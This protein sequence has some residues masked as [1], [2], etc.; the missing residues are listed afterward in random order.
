MSSN[1][2]QRRKDTAILRHEVSGTYL[3]TYM[4]PAHAPIDV[5]L[6]RNAISYWFAHKKQRRPWCPSCRANFEDDAAVGGF[7]LS[8]PVPATA[9]SVTAICTECLAALSPDDLDQVAA[10]VLQKLLPGGVFLDRA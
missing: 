6:L 9:A 8:T 2:S 5:P 10:L 1:R 7:L 3:L 4:L